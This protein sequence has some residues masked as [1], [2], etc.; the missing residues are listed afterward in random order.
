MGIW[1]MCLV[2]FCERSAVESRGL[3]LDFVDVL[4]YL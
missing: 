1:G 2:G 4:G 3:A